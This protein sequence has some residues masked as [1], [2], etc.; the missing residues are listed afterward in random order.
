MSY[1]VD[2]PHLYYRAAGYVSKILRGAK[3]AELPIEQPTKFYLV[4]N[5]RTART[6]GL[7]IPA[8]LLKR[9][10]RIIG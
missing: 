2:Y 3:P 5:R 4:I 10:D 7:A 1:G 9:A 6:L 8:A